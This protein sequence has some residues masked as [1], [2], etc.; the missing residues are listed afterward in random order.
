MGETN[1][2]LTRGQLIQYGYRVAH[3]FEC[4][5][6]GQCVHCGCDAEGRM[7]SATDS[8]S[9]GKWGMMITEEQLDEYL[10]HPETKLQLKVI[11][12]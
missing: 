8:C 10:N 11:E 12:E 5:K 6:A 3:C 7:N 9:A 2:Y 4:I 1:T